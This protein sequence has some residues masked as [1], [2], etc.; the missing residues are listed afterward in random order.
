MIKRT[1]V[2]LE[3]KGQEVQ[4]RI[5]RAQLETISE[6]I[7]MMRDDAKEKVHVRRGDLRDSIRSALIRDKKELQGYTF[8]GGPGARHA[9]LVE[10]GT[11]HSRA[12]PFVRPTADEDFPQ[13]KRKHREKVR[14]AIR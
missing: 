7:D 3:W 14:A 4:A 1:S 13:I 12:Y 11:V 10:G 5:R 9:H 2:K 8:A 6:G